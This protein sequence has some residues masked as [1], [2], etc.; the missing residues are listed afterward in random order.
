MATDS[1]LS[2]EYF[3]LL[4]GRFGLTNDHEI[5]PGGFTGSLHH[6]VATAAYPIGH[7]K[8]I[9]SE[10]G[11]LGQGGFTE[12]VYLQ[13]EG[14]DAPTLAARQFCVPGSA[15]TWYQFTNDPD[16]T[17]AVETGHAFAVVAISAMTDAYYGW[18]WCGGVAPGD[19][20]T[21]VGGANDWATNGA[22]AIDSAIA[23]NLS[24]DAIGLGV[25]TS[26]E[27]EIIG[28]SGV[29]DV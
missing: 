2:A 19:L 14:T 16:A 22:V 26:V 21:A 15:T 17:V 5:P 24:A 28:W 13:Y 1:T 27:E 10:S 12:F 20:V 11:V 9:P 6:N 4:A 29:A 7:V 23:I 25:Q 8:S 3:F 18:F